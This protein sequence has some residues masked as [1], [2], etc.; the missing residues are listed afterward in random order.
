MSRN[1]QAHFRRSGQVQLQIA[2][3]LNIWRYNVAFC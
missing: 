1:A 2:I 3:L